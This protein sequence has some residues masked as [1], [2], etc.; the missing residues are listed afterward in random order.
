MSERERVE[1]SGPAAIGD[2][3]VAAPDA[4]PASQRISGDKAVFRGDDNGPVASSEHDGFA[5]DV[6]P[7]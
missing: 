5:L 1:I 4:P 3:V 6:F 7:L 2:E